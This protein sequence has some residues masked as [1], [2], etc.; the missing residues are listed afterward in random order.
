MRKISTIVSKI[1]QVQLPVFLVVTK[2]RPTS[3]FQS[4]GGQQVPHFQLRRTTTTTWT[5][6]TVPRIGTMLMCRRMLGV[7]VRGGGR[8]LATSSHRLAERYFTKK[9]EWVLV[10]GMKGEWEQT[11]HT[12]RAT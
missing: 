10:D 3:T 5:K 2:W 9:H 6:M 11:F 12:V 7:G 1:F 4:A 8:G